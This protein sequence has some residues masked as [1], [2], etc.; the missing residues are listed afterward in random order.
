MTDPQEV[1]Y[2][3][4]LVFPGFG[5][6]RDYAETIVE[7]ALDWLN[8]FKEEPGFRFAPPVSAHLE[9]VRDAEEARDRIAED[10]RVATVIMHDLGEDE[11]D[12]LVAHCY[13]RQIAAS[14]TV[15][16][17]R[18]TG[19]RGEQMRVVF[20]KRPANRPPAHT[21]AA[22]TLTDPLEEDEDT[23]ERVGDVIAVLALGVME[24]HWRQN[25][26][27]HRF[28]APGPSPEQE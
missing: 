24:H 12:E 22:G 13:E 18:R 21:L 4:L 14:Y 20:R 25:P 1:E 8:T 7:I 17:P 11:R 15:D 16:A 10:E 23:G 19:R 28:P 2:T 26:P 9:I 6:E 5:A 27:L 3:V